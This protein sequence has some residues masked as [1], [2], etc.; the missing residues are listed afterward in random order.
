MY[1]FYEHQG[2]KMTHAKRAIITTTIVGNTVTV[3]TEEF[4]FDDPSDSTMAKIVNE[5]GQPVYDTLPILDLGDQMGHTGYLDFL[6]P[7]DMTHPVMKGTD[8]HGRPF[9]AVRLVYT[10]RR[11]KT[12]TGVETLFRRYTDGPV[13]VSGG[14]GVC[15]SF[16]C[17]SAMT[18]DDIKY[19]GRVFRG[20]DA[21]IRDITY[22]GEYYEVP[23]GARNVKKIEDEGYVV[24]ET[25][26]LKVR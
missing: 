15:G 23:E 2:N 6:E 5:I 26:T 10:N 3:E 9:I 14:A 18:D 4:P 11:G 24:Y 8:I 22:P 19:F 20:E 16:F 21:G 1:L 25:G 12:R 17:I 13:W 7:S